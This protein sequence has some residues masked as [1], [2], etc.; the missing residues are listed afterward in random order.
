[1]SAWKMILVVAGSALAL[2]ACGGSADNSG[3]GG[4]GGGCNASTTVSGTAAQV[5][6]IVP[7]P[8]TIGAYDP[9]TV[10]VKVGQAVEWDWTDASSQHT[11]TA[12][13][14]SFDSGLCSQGTKFAYTFTKA[15]TFTYKCTIHSGMMGTVTV[16]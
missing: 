3:G 5:V 16:S 12:D 2:A 14:G 7:D 6:K 4:G 10:S 15:G 1:M 8:N 13:D 11:V 9:K